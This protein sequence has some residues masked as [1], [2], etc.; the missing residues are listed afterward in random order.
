MCVCVC[1]C[2]CVWCSSWPYCFP[3]SIPC[4]CLHVR[5]YVLHS[6]KIAH[7]QTQIIVFI[8]QLS[9]LCEMPSKRPSTLLQLFVFTPQKC[10]QKG[11]LCCYNCLCSPSSC[12]PHRNESRNKN[13]YVAYKTFPH[14]HCV[15]TAPDIHSAYM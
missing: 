1:V 6:K 13:V 10:Q 3:C 9:H 15:F 12:T 2:V 8:T 5:C 14:K 4:F 7:N 11:H